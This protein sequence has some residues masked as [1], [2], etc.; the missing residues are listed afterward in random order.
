MRVL[1]VLSVFVLISKL[2]FSHINDAALSQI[3][4]FQTELNNAYLD[5]NESPL[6][7]EDLAKFKGHA[8]FPVNLNYRV[9]AKVERITDAKEVTFPTTS[10]KF[11]QYI[12]YLKLS[13]FILKKQQVLYA[14]KSVALMNKEEYKDYLF[15]PF[16]D[17][18][19]GFS[20][21][22]GGRYI[23]LKEVPG[24][25][26]IIDFNQCYNPYC[27]YSNAYNCPIP[28]EINRLKIEIPAGVKAPAGH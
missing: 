17:K 8:F 16:A 9:T 25:F 3:Q 19:N 6:S 20:S 18:T 26:L 2:S 14:Y 13:F 12:P 1:V 27:A 7:K 21:Y 4:I 22:G 23:D 24:D 11:K 10:G 28:P 15:L 5:L